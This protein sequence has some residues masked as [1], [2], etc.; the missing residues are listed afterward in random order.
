[1]HCSAKAPE[2]APGRKDGPWGTGFPTEARVASVSGGMRGHGRSGRRR[3]SLTRRP[4]QVP[5]NGRGS[6][7]RP[8][9]GQKGGPELVSE[10]RKLVSENGERTS[11]TCLG[12]S[13][14][15][16]VGTRPRQ[17][18]ALAVDAWFSPDRSV[19]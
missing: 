16:G 11:L 12:T 3:R 7:R 6:D 13:L 9:A 8:S 4:P 15:P 1:M 19:E 14:A 17:G 5:R 2:P 18:S 10:V